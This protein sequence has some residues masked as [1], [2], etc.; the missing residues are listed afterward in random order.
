MTKGAGIS[1]IQF[2]AV[3]VNHDVDPFS[4]ILNLSVTTTAL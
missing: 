4:I 2:A 1:H 3:C